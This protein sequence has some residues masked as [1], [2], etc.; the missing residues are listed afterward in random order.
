MSDPQKKMEYHRKLA[1]ELRDLADKEKC[2]D[3]RQ[4]ILTKA[5]AY[6][7]LCE[8][9]QQRYSKPFSGHPGLSPT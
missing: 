1:Q 6:D 2:P 7:E 4:R 5:K 8:R 9:F 3:A